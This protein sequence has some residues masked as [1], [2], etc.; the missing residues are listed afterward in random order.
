LFSAVS[1]RAVCRVAGFTAAILW[2]SALTP[3]GLIEPSFI[4]NRFKNKL[5][6]KK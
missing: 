5:E 2:I 3:L 4:D 1:D 6:M